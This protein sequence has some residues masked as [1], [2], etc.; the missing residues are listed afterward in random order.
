VTVIPGGLGFWPL[1]GHSF[2]ILGTSGACLLLARKCLVPRAFLP[3]RNYLLEFL[4]LFDRKQPRPTAATRGIATAVET[5]PDRL[6]AD[7]PIAWRET[8][9]RSLGRPRYLLRLLLFIEIPLVLFCGLLV[10]SQFS[11]SND[12]TFVPRALVTMMIFL[13]WVPAVLVVAVQSASLIAGER[14]HQTL[15]V[16][17]TTPLTG[18]D[19]VLQKFAGVRRL[20]LFLMAPFATLFLCEVIIRRFSAANGHWSEPD[21][22]AAG[23]L[24]SS[25][26]TVLIY[27]PLVAWLSL[28]IGLK[29]R[30]QAR[31]MI[32]S[33]GA[34]VGWCVLPFLFCVTPLAIATNRSGDT[35][36]LFSTM[37]LSP[38]TV[39]LWNE[40]EERQ[41][42]HVFGDR[43]WVAFLLNFVGYGLALLLFRG[44]ALKNANRWLGRGEHQTEIVPANDDGLPALQSRLEGVEGNVDAFMAETAAGWIRKDTADGADARASD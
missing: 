31:A 9:K 27:L 1:V 7:A 38:A 20:T 22:N 42:L 33:L 43:V 3:P 15:D 14:S 28:A 18:R 34:I 12:Y 37:L 24:I 30:T 2:V 5:D 10:V 41:L 23:Y 26:L 13:L 8:T 16:L 29:V 6:P 39:V 21:F 4:K 11:R 44:M 36:L 25:V 40:I 19:I 17:C 35:A 32:G